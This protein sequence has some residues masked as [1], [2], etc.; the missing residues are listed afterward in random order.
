MAING[1]K[2]RETERKS[3]SLSKAI[4]TKQGITENESEIAK[5]FNNYFTSADTALAS[6]IPIVPMQCFDGA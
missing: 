6:K 5:E 2:N 1:R 3:S 4:K